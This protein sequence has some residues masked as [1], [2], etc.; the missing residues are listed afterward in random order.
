M[1][2]F[3]GERSAKQGFKTSR[4]PEF[5]KQEIDYINGTID[6]LGVNYYTTNMVSEKN[7][8]VR[9]EVSWEADAETI[10]FVKPEW[11]FSTTWLRVV[12][13]GIGKVM[14]WVKKTY[15]DIP[16]WITE[17]GMATYGESL[18]DDN[19]IEYYQVNIKKKIRK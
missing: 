2:K 5:T 19:R 13:W 18:E 9:N 4:L 1:K 10:R 3:I 17:N 12:P 6:F 15:G 8:T 11:P 16:I 14:H 7:D